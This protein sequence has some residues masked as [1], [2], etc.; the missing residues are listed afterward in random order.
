MFV[1]G[2]EAQAL[3]VD[4]THYGIRVRAFRNRGP[5]PRVVQRLTG[6]TFMNGYNVFNNS[7][8]NL[9]KG[10]VE[11]VYVV[12]QGG[13][14]FAR[15][16]APTSAAVK[17]VSLSLEAL[18]ELLPVTTPIS[19]DDFA[20]L[21]SGRK[22]VIYQKAVDELNRR[23][24]CPSDAQ[25][26]TFVK[27]EKIDFETKPDAV[28]RVIQPRNP[29]FNVEFGRYVKPLEKRIC[30]AIDQWFGGDTPVVMKGM[31]FEEVGRV[32][33][34]KWRSFVRPIAIDLDASRFDQHVSVPMLTLEHNVYLNCFR[35]LNRSRLQAL[36]RFQ[37]KNYCRG[38]AR[39]GSVKYV[40]DGCRMSGDM[41]T[42]L[43]NII[44]MT[45]CLKTYLDRLGVRVELVNNGDDS[46]LICEQEHYDLLT[47][48]TEHMLSCGFTMKV[49]APVGVLERVEFCQTRPVWTPRGYCMVRNPAVALRK[50]AMCLLPMH[51]EVLARAWSRDVGLC[52]LSSFGDIPVL[53]TL[54]ASMRDL[55]HGVNREV[56]H[57]GH[58]LRI[59]YGS[60][61]AVSGTSVH[62]L[63]RASFYFAFGVLPDQQIAVE[64]HIR[65]MQVLRAAPGGEAGMEQMPLL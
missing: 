47:G 50:D 22:R 28:P 37:L 40:I 25:V 56:K 12:K 14:G 20:A 16:P 3:T 29:R 64:N 58:S 55:G 41:N 18:S 48:L 52:G 54:Y 33:A 51:T 17:S 39:D 59:G 1:S 15:P 4:P 57:H 26:D 35:G 7:L 9:T 24:F 2:R 32:I 21:Y 46:V 62:S 8:H 6:L 5:K 53:S 43:G 44:I 30:R 49:G 61:G 27:C 31:T 60:K 23:G 34:R 11:R 13:G 63:T 38:R 45:A 19:R 10:I 42:S 36:C 65:S